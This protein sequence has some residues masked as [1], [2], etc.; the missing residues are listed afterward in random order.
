MDQ[1]NSP[2]NRGRRIVVH[3]GPY[4]LACLQVVKMD[5]VNKILDEEAKAKASTLVD[6]HLDLKFD[7][8]TLLAIDENEIKFNA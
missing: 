1:Q 5:I 2:K 6:K 8:G 4:G 3:I 7:L